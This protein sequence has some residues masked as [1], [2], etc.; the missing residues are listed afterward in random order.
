MNILRKSNLKLQLNKKTFFSRQN[1]SLLHLGTF[2][3]TCAHQLLG[4]YRYLS[5]I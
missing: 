4:A 5:D 2:L 1:E 3:N